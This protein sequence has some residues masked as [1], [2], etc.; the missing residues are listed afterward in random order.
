MHPEAWLWD[1]RVW[2]PVPG[3]F[4]Q[5]CKE[6]RTPLSEMYFRVTTAHRGSR[7]CMW[8]C[9]DPLIGIL[10]KS[11]PR[12]LLLWNGRDCQGLSEKGKFLGEL[13]FLCAGAYALIY[14]DVRWK[15]LHST[16][17]RFCTAF[18]LANEWL[19]LPLTP[20]LWASRNWHWTHFGEH[21]ESST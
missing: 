8:K 19:P 10:S 15:A 12:C 13:E 3:C 5:L 4:S 20:G 17:E 1:I 14:L 16:P 21:P 2:F 11:F 18:K 9:A 6:T 7:N